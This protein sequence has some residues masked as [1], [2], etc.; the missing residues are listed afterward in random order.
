MVFYYNILGELKMDFYNAFFKELNVHQTFE[1][2]VYVAFI[3][4][5]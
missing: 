3:A 2:F 4:L 5:N 1:G